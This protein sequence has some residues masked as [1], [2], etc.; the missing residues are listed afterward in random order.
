MSGYTEDHLTEQPAI[1]LMEHEL[2]WDSV[3]AYDEWC[4]GAS[5]LGREAKREVVLTGRLKLPA[6]NGFLLGWPPRCAVLTLQSLNP[7]LSDEALDAAVE[8]LT[9]D[10]SAL[11]LVEANR[12]ID[13]LLRGG[14]KVKIPD[15]ERGGQR[16]VNLSRKEAAHA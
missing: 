2:G 9:R 1:Q 15:R 5:S 8:E 3:N 4:S 16:T 6:G 10:R 13:K 11:S 14:V 7:E 12:E